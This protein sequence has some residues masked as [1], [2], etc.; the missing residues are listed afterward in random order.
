MQVRRLTGSN[1]VVIDISTTTGEISIS[2]NV[3]TINL[4][5]L[6]TELLP[7][8]EFKWDIEITSPDDVRD[9]LIEGKFTITPEVTK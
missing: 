3:I 7:C 6:D 4:H 8:G 5:Y 9:R 1:G 2:G